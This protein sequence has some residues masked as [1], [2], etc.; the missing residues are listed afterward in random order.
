MSEELQARLRELEEE[1]RLLQESDLF[2][3]RGILK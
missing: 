1:R 2:W 3:A